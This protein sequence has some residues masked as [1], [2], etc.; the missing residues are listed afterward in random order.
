[1]RRHGYPKLIAA[2][3]GPGSV[4]EGVEFMKS[5]D[6]VVDPDAC[7]HVVDELSSYSYEIDKK[8]DEVLPVLEDKKNHT[9]DACRYALEPLRRAAPVATFGWQRTA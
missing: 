3:K 6:I 2:K 7:P 1:M 5:Y 4:E 8:T 9:I